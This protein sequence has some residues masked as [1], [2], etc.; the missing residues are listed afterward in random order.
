MVTTVLGTL[1]TLIFPGLGQG[2]AGHTRRATLWAIAA[3][4]TQIAIA[5][6]VWVLMVHAALRIATV[7]D[8]SVCL[9]RG[10]QTGTRIA[11]ILV[12]VIVAVVGLFGVRAFAVEAFKI[13]ASS[14]VPTLG[15]G[16]HIFVDKLSMH[17]RAPRRGEVI[18]FVYPCNPDHDY[19]KRVI[20][21]GGDTVEV[22]C[23]VVYVNGT[24][25][26]SKLAEDGA[27]CTYDDH[28]D[29]IAG[30]ERWERRP[31]SH[32]RETLGDRT[33]DVLHDQNRPERDARGF[34]T[35]DHGDSRDFPTRN[36]IPGCANAVDDT[37]A[38]PD[39]PPDAGKIVETKPEGGA[40]ACEPQLH[41]VV[42][43][44]HV[45]VL[46]D[47]RFNSNDSRIWGSVPRSAVVGRVIG[48]WS[49]FGRFGAV[50]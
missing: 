19:V 29:D 49:P 46:G 7:I 6:S 40:Q 9:R 42:P 35:L 26:P 27:Q 20:A 30:A 39:V 25:V 37:G 22:R 18:V 8:A 10:R 34:A 13:P 31:C 2:I 5:V 47:N 38:E 45:F 4:V 36:R 23:N 16:D 50:H 33:Y 14:M 1:A 15:V 17:F 28:I 44:D 43:D 11:G 48:I 21:V 12:A 24:A 3:I 32:Y 41:Y